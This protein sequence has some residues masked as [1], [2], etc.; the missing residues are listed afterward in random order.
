MRVL[1]L[2]LLAVSLAPVGF[3]EDASEPIAVAGFVAGWNGPGWWTIDID[4]DGKMDVKIVSGGVVSR[5]LTPEEHRTLRALVSALPVDRAKYDFESQGP[6]DA[7]PIFEL[8]V[9]RAKV[10]RRYYFAARAAGDRVPSDLVALQRVWRFRRDR[11]ASDR[12]QDPG[13]VQEPT[14][15]RQRQ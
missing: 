8:T 5:R 13:P 7:T 4:V 3:P 1:T 15:P 2:A 12:A 11:F 9:R 6:V 14:T 10:V